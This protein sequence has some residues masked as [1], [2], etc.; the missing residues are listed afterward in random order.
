MWEMMY[1]LNTI[2][3]IEAKRDHLVTVALADDHAIVRQGVRT[4]L[5]RT[6]RIVGEATD[7]IEAIRLVERTHPDILVLDMMMPHLNGL[8]VMRQLRPR[9]PNLRMI[10]MSMHDDLPNV[11]QAVVA[12]AAG[13]VLKQS[14]GTD[15]I[16]AIQTTF[17]GDHFFSKPLCEEEISLYLQETQ[18]SSSDPLATLTTRE[19]E[20]LQLV[21][22]G[23]TSQQI[24]KLLF[25]SPR[26]A[27]VH[28]ANLMRK[29]KVSSKAELIRYAMTQGLVM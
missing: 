20:I 4:L 8:E 5:E 27:E 21:A 19:R 17:G 29:L 6:F 18:A 15:L 16:N 1:E 3:P 11:S 26:T 12:G 2:L 7:G 22:E 25:I 13:Y 14:N 23:H 24:G 10:V 28:R 9:F